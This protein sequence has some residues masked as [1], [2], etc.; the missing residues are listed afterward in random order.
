MT[1]RR[2][3]AQS[4]RSRASAQLARFR[5]SSIIAI[6]LTALL[7]L[8]FSPGEEPGLGAQSTPTAADTVA[9]IPDTVSVIR[10]IPTE[11]IREAAAAADS[12]STT[13]AEEATG[14]LRALWGG[15]VGNLPKYGVALAVLV[16]AWVVTRL[17]SA[18]LPRLLAHWGR[19]H[20]ITAL[21]SVV[22]WLLAFGIATSVLVGDIRALVGSLGLVGLAL[23]WAL[24]TPI[25]SFTGWMLNSFHGYYRVG[26]RIAVGEVFGDV[27][28]IDFHPTTVWEYGA[29]DRPPGWVHAEQ[30]TGRMITFPNNELLNGAVVNYTRDFPYVWDEYEQGIANESELALAIRVVESVARELL[31]DQMEEPARQYEAVLRRENLEREVADRP[32]VYVSTNDWATLLTV[33]YL[34]GV[35]EK[36]VWKSRLIQ[37]LAEELGKQE[38]R[39]RIIPVYPRRQVQSFEPDGTPA[40]PAAAQPP[41]EG[42]A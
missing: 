31:G 36:R 4:A 26:D 12:D 15:F 41:V 30:P 1:L 9:E 2:Q 20:A 28:R 40:A 39:G 13:S 22:I 5:Q 21:T 8:L 10:T 32:Q 27:Y 24:Q 34:V 17:W 6:G 38:Y 7:L 18:L 35:R 42:A 37:A 23:S 25:E 16:A 33:R 3:P 14:T 29:A 11:R 19:A